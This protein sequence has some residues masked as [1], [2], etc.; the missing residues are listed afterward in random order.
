MKYVDKIKEHDSSYQ[1]PNVTIKSN[2][3]YIILIILGVLGFL[4]WLFSD[5]LLDF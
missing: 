4:F 3:W 1:A 5:L 2:I